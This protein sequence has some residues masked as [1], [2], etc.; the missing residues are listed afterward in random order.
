MKLIRATL[1]STI[2]VKERCESSA[3]ILADAG[4]AHQIVMNLCTNAGLAM[5]ESGGVLEVRLDDLENSDAV[6]SKHPQ[7]AQG[8][9]V[10]LTVKDTG[11]GIPPENLA[12]IFEPFFTTRPAG[13]GTGLGLSVVHGIVESWGGAIGVS[14]E[15][16]KGTTFEVYLPASA[17]TATVESEPTLAHRGSERVLFVDDE[18]DLTEVARRG[19]SRF[20]YEV[21]VFN[22][23]RRALE[24]FRARPGDFDIVVTDMT[25]P[26]ITG[27]VLAT[28]VRRLR[29]E[30]PV[31]LVSGFSDR[32]TAEQAKTAGFDGFVDKP[33][34][35][36]SLAQLIRKLCG[37]HTSRVDP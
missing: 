12:R 20:G 8:S 16:G 36:T 32:F 24:A 37:V 21:T 23:P 4:Q 11:C 22:D 3:W 9:Y 5:R 14:S 27:D 30:I 31:V 34:R 28:E 33:L 26:G 13:Q 7:L 10:C 19:L 25:M 17:A 18:S 1:P 15:V 2:A 6:M 35:P 29:P